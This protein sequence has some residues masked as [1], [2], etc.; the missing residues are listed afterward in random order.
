MPTLAELQR[1]LRQGQY[2][3]FHFIGHGGFDDQAQDGVLILEDQEERGRRVSAQFLGTL[4]HDHRPLRLAVLNACEGARASRADPF[5]GTAQSLVQQG[6]PAVIAMQFEITDD[7]AI[8]FTREFYA[9]IAVGYPVDA[10]LAEARKAIFSEVS[11][12]EWGTP[13]LYM[14]SPD[15]LIFEVE[16]VSESDRRQQQIS[17]L[18]AAARTAVASNDETTAIARA[19][20]ALALDAGNSDAAALLREVGRQRDLAEAYTSARAQFDEGRFTEALQSLQHVRSIERGYRDVDALIASA[21][22][23]LAH[24]ADV[25]ARARHLDDLRR[26][27]KEATQ[28]ENWDDAIQKWQALL[29]ETPDDHD[30]RAHLSDARKQQELWRYYQRGRSHYK[31]RHLK[32]ALVE[33]HQL[34]RIANPYRDVATLVAKI[35]NE[36]KAEA[37]ESRPVTP[38]PVTPPSPVPPPMSPPP[39]SGREERRPIQSQTPQTLVT[40]G[41]APP[42]RARWFVMGGLLGAVAV[43]GVLVMAIVVIVAIYQNGVDIR[44]RAGAG[45]GPAPRR[46]SPAATSSSHHRRRGRRPSHLRQRPLRPRPLLLPIPTRWSRRRRRCGM[47]CSKCSST[48]ATTRFRRDRPRIRCCCSGT[49]PAPFSR[50]AR[51]RSRR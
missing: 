35:E 3:I 28:A 40:P 30:V 41:A 16:Q 43:V 11:E 49:T 26:G 37:Q 32:E 10:A 5:A 9:A 42:A 12:I 31:L 7:A 14:R 24:A 21:E 23:S 51:P 48:R 25:A 47:S 19:K 4:L 45:P 1:K 46:S 2:H 50:S 33:F 22:K 8:C 27:A 39:V 17:S 13:V 29:V 18:I 6:I 36:I 15:G 34:L 38:P 44:A 20:E